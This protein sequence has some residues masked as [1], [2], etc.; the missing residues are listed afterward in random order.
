[1]LGSAFT[2][3]HSDARVLDQL[4]YKWAHSRSVIASVLQ[5]EYS[6]LL[7]AGWRPSRSEIRRDVYRLFGGSYEEFMNKS[8]S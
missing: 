5:D 8:L 1:M 6:K 4:I 7:L 3:Q 2:S